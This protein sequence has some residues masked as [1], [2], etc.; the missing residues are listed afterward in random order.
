MMRPDNRISRSCNRSRRRASGLA[1]FVTLVTLVVLTGLVYGLVS[2]ISMIRH[3]QQYMID[4]QNA[5]YACDSGM[6]YAMVSLNTLQLNLIKR[7]D[8]PDFSDLFI[9]DKA[10]YE[11]YLADWALYKQQLAMEKAAAEGGDTTKLASESGL[12][13]DLFKG[14]TNLIKTGSSSDDP[15]TQT[16]DSVGDQT[17]LMALADPNSIEIPGP[18]GPEWPYVT[19]PLEFELGDAKIRIEIADE[20][21]KLP[22]VWSFTDNSDLRRAAEDSTELFC[23]WMQMNRE[24]ITDLRERLAVIAEKKAFSLKPKPVTV[25]VPAP[26]NRTTSRTT[27]TGTGGSRSAESRTPTTINVQQQ[28][29]AIAASSDFVRL[30]TSSLI[31]LE[32]LARPLPNTGKR[33]EAPIKYLG[34]WGATQVNINTAPRHVLEATFLFGGDSIEIADGIIKQRREKPFKDTNELQD[35]LYAYGESIRKA[36]PYITTTSN[37]LTIRVTARCGTATA[38]SLASVI[39]NDKTIQTIAMVD[40][41]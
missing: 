11:Q 30:L 22:L 3:R 26:A 15:N 7:K 4:Y 2:R 1:L 23:E 14:L 35:K 19:K 34:L 13:K 33:Y 31:D 40:T 29:T 17:D 20:N 10:E 38:S 12:D 6:K 5:R 32:S 27:G 37:C 16:S 28:R 41:R 39:K 36:L 24:Q 9:K 25:S 21:A 8:E 18:Y